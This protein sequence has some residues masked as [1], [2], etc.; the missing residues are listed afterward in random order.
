MFVNFI[1]F[2]EMEP[3]VVKNYINIIQKHT[4]KYVLTRNSKFGKNISA[5]PTDVGVIDQV[6]LDYILSE[7]NDFELIARDFKIFGEFSGKNIS[8]LAIL[9]RKD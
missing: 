7:F 9:K 2:Q 5:K 3:L 6:T 4:K 8:E 1:S